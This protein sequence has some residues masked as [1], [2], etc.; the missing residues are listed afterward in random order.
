MLKLPLKNKTEPLIFLNIFIDLKKK[1][2]IDFLLQ[3]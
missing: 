3:H 2:T 1:F